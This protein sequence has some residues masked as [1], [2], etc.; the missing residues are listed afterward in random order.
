MM[1]IKTKSWLKRVKNEL[2]EKALLEDM[3]GN[4]KHLIV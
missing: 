2:G 4:K 3:D 1:K